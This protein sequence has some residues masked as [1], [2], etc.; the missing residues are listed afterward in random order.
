MRLRDTQKRAITDPAHLLADPLHYS[1]VSVSRAHDRAI[2]QILEQVFRVPSESD[3]ETP[4]ELARRPLYNRTNKFFTSL[5]VRQLVD[6]LPDERDQVEY[7]RRV[8]EVK[9]LYGGLSETYQKGK[10]AVGIPLA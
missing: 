7:R 4:S 9:E 2:T 10:G 8:E 5:S 6:D 3:S 1:L